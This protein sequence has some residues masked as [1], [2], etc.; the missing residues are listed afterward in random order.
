L[1]KIERRLA[2]KS[3]MS[4]SSTVTQY[5]P[6]FMVHDQEP[7]NQPS[8]A[9]L[10]SPEIEAPPIKILKQATY[11]PKPTRKEQVTVNQPALA[12][13]SSS[14]ITTQDP[15]PQVPQAQGSTRFGVQLFIYRTP[16]DKFRT[17]SPVRRTG[18]N[19]R[20]ENGKYYPNMTHGGFSEETS[21]WAI[22]PKV[23]MALET[24]SE[25]LF[26]RLR[27]PS[28]LNTGFLW[29]KFTSKAGM[30]DFVAH[31][32]QAVPGRKMPAKKWEG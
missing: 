25:H 16:K 8:P 12:A 22:D 6:A 29:V 15:A 9:K 17:D 2:Q 14:S 20:Y 21:R 5:A 24:S 27:R 1:E 31:M 10:T 3:K 19:L 4:D 32:Q 28:E 11:S 30:D 18:M 23:V 13:S 26:V 7:N